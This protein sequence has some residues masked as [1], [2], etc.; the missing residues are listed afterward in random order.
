MS[1]IALVIIVVLLVVAA[2]VAGTLIL[3]R[4]AL[5][6][7]F[8]GEYDR[9]ARAVGPRRAETELTE[10]QRRVAR[11]DLRPLTAPQRD[12]YSREW[13]SAEERFVDSPAQ[14]AEA[15]RA[16]IIAVA[17]DRGYPADDH[18]QLLSDLSVNHARQLGDYRQAE[19][20]T[21]SGESDTEQLRHALLA[22]R[23]LFN[24]LVGAQDGRDGEPA[25]RSG[26][27]V[28][29]ARAPGATE[30]AGTGADGTAATGSGE[31]RATAQSTRKE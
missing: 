18:E 14:A 8:D 2:A 3:R 29:G 15:G 19:Q 26:S 17:A 12:R 22:Y 27:E 21:G 13:T 7:R 6:R 4:Q 20:T 23:A 1:T 28:T 24:E 11:L 10:R 16:L 30:A 31:D 5:R 25:A 9:L